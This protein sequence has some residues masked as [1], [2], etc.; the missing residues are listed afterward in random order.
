[1]YRGPEPPSFHSQILLVS[2]LPY[3]VLVPELLEALWGETLLG[4]CRAFSLSFYFLTST[5]ELPLN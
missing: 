4:T 2:V 3:L 1:M 5:V